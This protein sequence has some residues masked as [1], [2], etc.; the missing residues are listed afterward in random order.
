MKKLGISRIIHYSHLRNGTFTFNFFECLRIPLWSRHS[1][2]LTRCLQLLLR[3]LYGSIGSERDADTFGLSDRIIRDT[4]WRYYRNTILLHVGAI[5]RLLKI[6]YS[7]V[8][9]LQEPNVK[10]WRLN[11]I[12]ST[13]WRCNE[14]H[15]LTPWSSYLK[16]LRPEDDKND[17]CKWI[18]KYMYTLL[19]LSFYQQATVTRVLKLTAACSDKFWC[20]Y[21]ELW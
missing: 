4:R 17:R 15:P 5:R 6:E 20:N 16:E 1:F 9:I 10:Y 7:D 21:G 14:N 18:R 19:W 11:F 3:R 12:L 2:V 13:L 8:T